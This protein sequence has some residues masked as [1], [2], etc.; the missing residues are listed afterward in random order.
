MRALLTAA[1]VLAIGLGLCSG[2]WTDAWSAGVTGTPGAPGSNSWTYA[3]RNT[4]TASYYS[5]WVFTIEVDDV[6]GVSST[7]TP[8]GWSVDTDSEP[9][10][11]TWMYQTGELAA[12]K[13]VT[14]FQATFTSEPRSQAYTAL[15][16]DSLNFT[17][18]Y[19]E[20]PV[21]LVGAVPE[22][23]SLLVLLTGCGPLAALAL[24]R[25]LRH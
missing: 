9:H 1:V 24:R 14:G 17:C 15:F 23:G 6:C 20:G 25:K 16:N 10:F 4:S 3:V 8:D 11:I 13:E 19:T 21:T 2:A 22:P 18:P 12:G 5:L 7:V